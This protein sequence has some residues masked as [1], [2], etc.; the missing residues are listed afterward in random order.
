MSNLDPRE[1]LLALAQDFAEDADERMWPLFAPIAVDAGVMRDSSG[2]H[3][4]LQGKIFA[5]VSLEKA[6]EE[7]FEQIKSASIKQV[8]GYATWTSAVKQVRG[9]ATWTSAAIERD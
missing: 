2:D 5:P 8:R 4:L 9:Y 1:W 6:A 3:Y 7:L